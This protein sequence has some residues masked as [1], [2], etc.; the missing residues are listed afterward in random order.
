[1]DA[2]KYSV[3]MVTLS[4]IFCV[5]SSSPFFTR[6]HQQLGLDDTISFANEHN[7]LHNRLAFMWNFTS[8]SCLQWMKKLRIWISTPNRVLLCSLYPI[9]TLLG[10]FA[11]QFW[12][13]KSQ[14]NGQGLLSIKLCYFSLL[15]SSTTNWTLQVSQLCNFGPMNCHST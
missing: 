4:L 11:F 7:Y 2:P 14:L 5:F 13:F 15:S 12:L 3:G 6:Q 8:F 9:T 10:K 1:M